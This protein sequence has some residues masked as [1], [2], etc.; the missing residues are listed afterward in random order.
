MIARLLAVVL[1][2]PPATALAADAP[3][4]GEAA[5]AVDARALVRKV[6]TQ[7]QG[8]SSHGVARMVVKTPAW[9]REMKLEIWSKGREKFLAKIL[10]PKKDAGTATLKIGDEMWN[11]LPKIDRLMKIPSS[12]MGDRWMGSNLTNDDLVREV[13]VDELYDFS[14]PKADAHAATVVGVPKPNAAV[15]WGKVVYEIDR[16]KNV[17]REIQ[18]F[19]EDNA[20]VRTISFD[21]VAQISGQWVAKR[22]QV[23]PEDEPGESTVLTYEEL[24]LNGDVPESLFS[25]RN[26]RRR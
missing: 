19:D 9:T 18:Y 6:E 24:T 23:K 11:Y 2:L 20:L 10:E 17:P 5:E 15:V 13:K 7:Y 4:A 25:V 21:D 12:L 8:K 22:M 1:L 16:D 14:V 26:L 3:P